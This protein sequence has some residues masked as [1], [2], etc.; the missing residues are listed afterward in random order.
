MGMWRKY[1]LT[2]LVIGGYIVAVLALVAAQGILAAYGAVSYLDS[3]LPFALL[4]LVAIGLVAYALK[5]IYLPRLV[6]ETKEGGI[7]ATAEVLEAKLTGWRMRHWRE[8]Q[9]KFEHRLRLRVQGVKLSSYEATTYAFLLRGAAPTVGSTVKVR[10][11]PERHEI[12]VL[13]SAA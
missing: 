5:R 9:R 4:H 12:V 7:S 6:Q 1:G 10:V 3:L 13:D 2:W 8:H 11:H